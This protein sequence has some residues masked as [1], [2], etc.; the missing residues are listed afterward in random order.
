MPAMG[1]TTLSRRRKQLAKAKQH[2]LW[3]NQSSA[4]LL[5]SDMDRQSPTFCDTDRFNREAG[6]DLESTQHSTAERYRQR[7]A[8]SKWSQSASCL[9][10]S[11]DMPGGTCRF[12]PRSLHSRSLRSLS[13]LS[14]E[15]KVSRSSSSPSLQSILLP[16]SPTDKRFFGAAAS[17]EPAPDSTRLE[18]LID[19]ACRDKT[20]FQAAVSEFEEDLSS[21]FCQTM[22]RLNRLDR[23]C[24]GSERAGGAVR[25]VG[26]IWLG[27]F[28]QRSLLIMTLLW[29]TTCQNHAV[30]VA[31]H[32]ERWF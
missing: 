5:E 11:L 14:S 18:K 23:L 20:S 19:S 13:S 28:Q 24:G 30:G 10:E 1:Q 7:G 17:A 25:C 16:Q 21:E 2:A 22:H 8:H 3:L 4:Q 27:H 26:F 31:D 29:N 32:W 12:Q 15:S 6:T 9:S